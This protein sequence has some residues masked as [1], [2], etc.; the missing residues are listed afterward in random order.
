VETDEGDLYW[1]PGEFAEEAQQIKK[2]N[3]KPQKTIVCPYFIL[4]TC[5][6]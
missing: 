4:N 5:L 1:P 3:T 2:G 6:G